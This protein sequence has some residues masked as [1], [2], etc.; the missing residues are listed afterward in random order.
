MIG[1]SYST[2]GVTVTLIEPERIDVC[3]QKPDSE[4]SCHVFPGPV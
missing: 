2:K 3:I 1:Y 4:G